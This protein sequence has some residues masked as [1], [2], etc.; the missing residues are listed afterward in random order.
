MHAEYYHMSE[1]TAALLNRVK[2]N[3]GRIIRHQLVR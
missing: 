1:E 2:E 3:G